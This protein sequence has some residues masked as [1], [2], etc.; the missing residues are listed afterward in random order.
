MSESTLIAK[1]KAEAV[2]SVATIKAEN[3]VALSKLAH[4][5]DAR[6]SAMKA[7]HDLMLKKKLAQMELVALSKAK[8][9]ANIK[10]QQAK[11]DEVDALFSAVK[12]RLL[13][14]PA[15]DYVTF[16][17]THVKRLVPNDLGNVT[18][19]T[20]EKRLSEAKEIISILGING[21]IRTDYA[22]TAGMIIESEDGVYDV[23][24]DR[25]MEERRP[26]LEMRVLD[27]LK[28]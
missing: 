11:R 28:A 20:A 3:E 8:Q 22:I 14:Q 15:G 1:I 23:T 27:S 6:I 24:L 26:E 17:S 25:L 16:F 19:R 12:D 2:A 10:L 9:E 5:F 7:E 18:I 21:E 4:D 13:M